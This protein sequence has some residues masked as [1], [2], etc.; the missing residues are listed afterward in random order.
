MPFIK[1]LQD[2]LK[3]EGYEVGKNLEIDLQNAQGDQSNL[4]ACLKN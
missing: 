2:E 4:A 3:N 1:G